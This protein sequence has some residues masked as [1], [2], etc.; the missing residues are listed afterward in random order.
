MILHIKVKPNARRSALTQAE[1]GSWSASLVAQPVDGKAND[2]LVALVA[3]RFAC[4]KAD[5]SIKSGATSR[6]KR[7]EI[8]DR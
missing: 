6:V 3:R 7:I 2:E 1:D 4:R 8:V 5:V